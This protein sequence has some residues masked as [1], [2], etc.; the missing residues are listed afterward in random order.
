MITYCWPEALL[1]TSLV[2]CYMYYILYFT[3]KYA[4]EKKILLRKSER[5][6]NIFTVLYCIYGK[7]S[8]CKWTSAVQIHVVQSSTINKTGGIRSVK[9]KSHMHREHSKILPKLKL[10][11]NEIRWIQNTTD[12]FSHLYKWCNKRVFKY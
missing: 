6:E 5:R 10:M 12:E 3:I 7:K 2:I 4:R 11:R 9:L 1:M 8:L